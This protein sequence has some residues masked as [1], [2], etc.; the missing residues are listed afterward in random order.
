MTAPIAIELVADSTSDSETS[1]AL[2]EACS[3]AAGAGGCILGAPLDDD[4][5]PRARV[6]VVFFDGSA[7]VRVSLVATGS[8]SGVS[9]EAVFH[10]GDP[11]R[12]RFRAA[13]LIAAGLVA[14][15]EATAAEPV[16][17]AEASGP[18][19]RESPA[20][21][22]RTL[23][24]VGGGIGWTTE[25]PWIYGQLGADFMVAPPFVV[26]LSGGYGRT[27]SRDD[28]GIAEQ[29]ASFG[30]GPGVAVPL[31]GSPWSLHARVEAE[32]QRVVAD[33]TQPSTG[34]QDEGGRTFV[35]VGAALEIVFPVAGGLGFFLGDRVDFW[36]SR[37]AVRV[38]GVP[39]ESIGT[40]LDTATVGLTVRIP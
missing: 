35:G 37:T 28:A 1:R 16:T 5:P 14:A 27:W 13:G 17:G 30:A 12:E 3:D 19:P 11:T 29:W 25:R 24:R 34:L 15:A 39:V 7:R 38:A 40:W 4:T 2:V 23:V 9:R 26:S 8:G 33:V 18:A 22:G 31:F 36:G 10:D 32:V 6:V 21:V 20:S